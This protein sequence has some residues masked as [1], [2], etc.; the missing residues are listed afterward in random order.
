MATK[1]KSPSVDLPSQAD[2]RAPLD[3][4]LL[5]SR[6]QGLLAELEADLLVRARSSAAVRE[7]LRARHE[8]E[9]A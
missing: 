7:A 9:R 6:S 5:L 1:K 3:G 4:A 8:S 2:P